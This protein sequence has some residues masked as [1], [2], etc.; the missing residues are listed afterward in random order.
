MLLK[1]AVALLALLWLSFASSAQVSV[2]V[3]PSNTSAIDSKN[4]QRIFL[5]K[6]KKFA[7]GSEIVA[8]NLTPDSDARAYFDENIVGRSTS[9]VSAYW[10]KLVFTGK[11]IP[12]KEVASDQEVID[13]VSQNPAIIGYVSTASVTD[14][15]KVVE[16]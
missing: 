16:L 8:L 13:L 6:D 11:G 10:S 9:Q 2:I 15:V 4:V 12:P 5:G 14:A 3:H 1:R 7:N